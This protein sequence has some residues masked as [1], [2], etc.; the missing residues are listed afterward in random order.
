MRALW[1]RNKTPFK[2]GTRHETGGKSNA[3]QMPARK[4]AACE[5]QGGLITQLAERTGLEPATSNVTGWR[6]N[7]LNYR[8]FAVWGRDSKRSSRAGKR[9]L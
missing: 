1:Q 3:V 4:K 6:S 8:S 5:M 7:Q 9:K 2:P